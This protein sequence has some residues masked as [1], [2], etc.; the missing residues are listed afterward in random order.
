MPE[1]SEHSEHSEHSE[2]SEFSEFSE[3]YAS[4]LLSDKSVNP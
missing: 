3:N 4:N 2:F 1:L